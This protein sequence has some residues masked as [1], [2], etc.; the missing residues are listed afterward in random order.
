[1]KSAITT[2]ATNVIGYKK[3]HAAKKPWITDEM[4]EKMD[5]RRKWMLIKRQKKHKH[6]TGN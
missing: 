4:L 1:L 3:K 5:E 2:A 6:S